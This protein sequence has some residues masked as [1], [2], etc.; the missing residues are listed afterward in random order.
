MNRMND[1]MPLAIIY[2]PA[3]NDAH[4]GFVHRYRNPVRNSF[5][6][7]T[8]RGPVRQIGRVPRGDTME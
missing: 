8:L 5:R 2:A 4:R 3:S 1:N 6:P 7:E